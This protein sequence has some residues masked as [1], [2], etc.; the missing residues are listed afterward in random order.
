MRPFCPIGAAGNS[1]TVACGFG[2]KALACDADQRGRAGF[3]G[4]TV[5]RTVGDDDDAALLWRS[6]LNRSVSSSAM[7]VAAE[8]EYGL[9]I[10][11][12]SSEAAP[13]EVRE[14]P[15]P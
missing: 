5:Q 13:R 14:L 11:G 9:F 3:A 7:A 2:G 15:R 4:T 1:L 10:N 8:R 6:P 12:E